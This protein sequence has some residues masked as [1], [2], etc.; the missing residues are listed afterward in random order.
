V[1]QWLSTPAPLVDLVHTNPNILQHTPG[2][3]D[4][5]QLRA[6]LRIGYWAWELEQFPEGWQEH[7][8]P[9]AEIWCPSAFTAQA[10]AQRSPI[11]VV[12]V[13]HLPDWPQLDRLHQRRQERLAAERSRVASDPKPFR[14]VCLFDY[15]STTERKNP[16]G[17]IEAFQRAFPAGGQRSSPVELW[18]KSSSASAFPLQAAALK[19]QAAADSRI[20]WLETLLP[21]QQM[22]QFWLQADALVSLHRA[23]GFGLAI[24]EAMAMGLPVIATGYSGNLEFSPVGS[25]CLIPWQPQPIPHTAGDYPA[26]AIWAEP[27]LDAA[28]QA[29]QQLAANHKA[30]HALGD[31]GRQAAQERLSA[32]RISAIVRQR[33]G[34]QLLPKAQLQ[35]P[36]SQG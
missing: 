8:A 33:L 20:H 6:P 28:A 25:C 5:Q 27:D 19:A 16:G 4:P 1:G 3:L 24:A 17:V 29:M 22:E 21:Q 36:L 30:A 2:L 13:P 34:L 12:A 11:P 23:E 9:M 32:R 31:R 10:L 15:W 7:F 18:I 35:Q 26:G 14:F